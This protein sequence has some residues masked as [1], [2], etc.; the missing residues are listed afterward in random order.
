MDVSRLTVEGSRRKEYLDSLRKALKSLEQ[1]T[2]LEQVSRY[3]DFAE[4]LK[5]GDDYGFLHSLEVFSDSG[6]PSTRVL[7]EAQNEKT[8]A[9][10]SMRHL[11]N[12]ESIIRSAKAKIYS[13]AIPEAEQSV[14]KKRKYFEKAFSLKMPSKKKS[15]SLKGRAGEKNRYEI[16]MGNYEIFSFATSGSVDHDVYSNYRIEIDQDVKSRS[17]LISDIIGKKIGVNEPPI[18]RVKKK[19][20]G[21]EVFVFELA[22]D[23]ENRLN[24]LF[25]KPPSEN[26]RRL[27]KL[28]LEGVEQGGEVKP[29]LVEKMTIGPFHIKENYSGEGLKEQY[30]NGGY[31]L[32]AE[33]R[34][35][36]RDDPVERST[37][38]YVCSPN[39]R[40]EVEKTVVEKRKDDRSK[41]IEREYFVVV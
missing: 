29:Y 22:V 14:A 25:G 9:F 4:L 26:L 37:V 40:E 12:Y 33:K 41:G 15:V 39:L 10:N 1:K 17:N 18:R 32:K 20:N 30:A 11:P 2:G 5:A 34:V 23:F 7:D 36:R 13:G 3:S 24:D 31:I 16:T 27:E 6:L 28:A 38:W 35:V 19:E 8:R 21:S